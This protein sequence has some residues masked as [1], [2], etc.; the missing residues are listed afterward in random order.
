MSPASRRRIHSGFSRC[1][2]SSAV[3]LSPAQGSSGSVLLRRAWGNRADE[4]NVARQI[5]SPQCCQEAV[6][7]NS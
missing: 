6:D 2:P 4:F 5:G 1:G 7:G 3:R